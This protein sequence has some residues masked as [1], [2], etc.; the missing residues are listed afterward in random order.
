MKASISTEIILLFAFFLLGVWLVYKAPKFVLVKNETLNPNKPSQLNPAF[1]TDEPILP[2]SQKDLFQQ[3]ITRY[4]QNPD[5]KTTK[6]LLA[7]SQQYHLYIL[8][9][10]LYEQL[11][12]PEK[13][14]DAYFSILLLPYYS[15]E[16]QQWAAQKALSLIPNLTS[17]PKEKQWFCQ[18][19]S[20]NEPP[21]KAIAQLRQHLN[22][23]PSYESYLYMGILSYHS[24]QME[25]AY[26][27]LFKAYTNK[28]NDYL[29]LTYLYLVIP[30]VFATLHREVVEQQLFLLLPKNHPLIIWLKKEN[31]NK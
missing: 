11:N 19:L 5:L 15:F 28:K 13:A 6:E 10:Q 30:K 26:D 18:A 14:F 25:K 17:I 8:L 9:G 29:L 1:R 23:N 2:P 31:Q 21:M 20:G 3:L 22:E 16:Q 24:N 27:Y 12:E 4:R 7:L